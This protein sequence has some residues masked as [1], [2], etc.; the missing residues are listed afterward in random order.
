MESWL[1]KGLAVALAI[2]LVV[3]GIG[4]LT[5]T[6][7][8]GNT[9]PA[10]EAERVVTED[11]PSAEAAVA[12][13][14]E[15]LS[16]PD[17][18]A[19]VTGSQED[20]TAGLE[21]FVVATV[22]NLEIDNEQLAA[23]Y[24]DVYAYYGQFY[25]QFGMDIAEFM[26]TLDGRYMDLAIQAQALDIL[27]R[28]A[29][30]ELEAESRGITVS[31][32][33][34]Q[35]QFDVLYAEYL[36]SN[37]MSEE[38]LSY[39]LALQGS[40]LD[41]FK[42]DALVNIR[43]GILEDRV[44]DAVVG[45]IDASDEDVEAYFAA[46]LGEFETEEQVRASHILVSDSAAGQD[47]LARLEAGEAFEALAVELSEDPGSASSG[48]DLGWFGRNQMVAEF[49]DAAFSL[50]VGEMS[51]LVET[52]YGFHIILV[53]DK[54]AAYT[55]TLDEVEQDVRSAVEAEAADISFAVWY[56]EKR[57]SGILAVDA[58]PLG[59]FYW[60]TVN[61]EEGLE[62]L[63]RIADSGSADDPYIDFYLGRLYEEQISSLDRELAT[64]EALESP[65]AEE[66]D[67]LADL[68][69]RLDIHIEGAV[70][71]YG[72]YAAENEVDEAY[73][74]NV[75]QLQSLSRTAQSP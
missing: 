9:V 45:Q 41:E 43:R 22:G 17:A 50:E 64:L 24:A 59:A 47:V 29:I 12:A 33:E 52:D 72:A 39:Y 36:T 56:D 25:A 68:T 67:R 38:D 32:T 69:A 61:P 20:E 16:T 65:S 54:Q 31:L 4:M 11:A 34:A 49:E 58:E 5:D 10:A 74:A 21:R 66:A 27:V 30:Y 42:S 6:E 18:D 51:D 44:R 60:Y 7:D 26:A 2:A 75:E 57:A 63:Q 73:S 3:L 28:V 14:D 71:A 62:R 55:P 13:I 48:G 19:A 46:H 35:Q 70:A 40:S 15:S 23:S 37:G 53:T 1:L 8:E